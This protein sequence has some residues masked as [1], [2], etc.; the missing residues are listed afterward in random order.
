M[1][2]YFKKLWTNNPKLRKVAGVTLIII[3]LLSII[4]PFTPVGF[5]L[6]IGLEI[7]GL[8]ALYWD[9]LKERFKKK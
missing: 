6:V 2:A 9:K 7:L 5:L 4:T 3:G 8:R 1:K